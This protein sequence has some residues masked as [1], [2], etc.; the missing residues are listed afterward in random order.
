VCAE[1]AQ[2]FSQHFDGGQPSMLSFYTRIHVE[3]TQSIWRRSWFTCVARPLIHSGFV[4]GFQDSL[5]SAGKTGEKV[6]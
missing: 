2:R 1:L 4:A 5:S 6:L 3:S